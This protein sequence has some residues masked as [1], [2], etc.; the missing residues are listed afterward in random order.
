M[1]KL[2]GSSLFPAAETPQFLV[3]IETPTAR[4]WP[5]PTAPCAMSN[6]G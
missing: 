6:S 4:P 5:A 3:R 1:M 2:I